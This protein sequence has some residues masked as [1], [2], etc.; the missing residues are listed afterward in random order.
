M[1]Y[2]G[3]TRARPTPSNDS[4]LSACSL[5]LKDAILQRGDL[6]DIY[7]HL[8]LVLAS[9]RPRYGCYLIDNLRPPARFTAYTSRSP[10]HSIPAR[11]VDSWR[12]RSD[13]KRHLAL[14]A[15]VA[16]FPW[17][18]LVP[19]HPG[20]HGDLSRSKVLANAFSTRGYSISTISWLNRN[21]AC[22]D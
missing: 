12:M 18:R 4:K 21:K 3:V 1:P 14:R 6:T 2:E 13:T 22:E 10:M 7:I 11:Q 19:W 16:S 9:T 20:R 17:L 15:H 8:N 5:V